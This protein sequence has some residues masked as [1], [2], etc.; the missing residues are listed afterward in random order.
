[1]KL[2]TLL[3]ASILTLSAQAQQK[4]DS[5]PPVKQLK[6]VNVTA[7]A[8][9]ITMQGGTMV[10]NVSKSATAAGATAWEVLQKAPG[11]I[12]DNTDNLQLNGKSVTVYIDGRPSRLSGEDLKTFLNSTPAGSIDKLELMSNPSTKYDAQ[13][14][15]IINI[16]MLKSKDF[17]TNG[18]LNLSAG[19]GRYPRT[20]EGFT[21]NHRSNNKVN[22][23]GSYDHLYARQFTHT[24]SDRLFPDAYTLEDSDYARDNR[25]SHNLKAGAD[26][27][28]SKNT[29]AG[30]LL[31]G[32]FSNRGRWAENNTALNAGG[33]STFF[34]LAEGKQ[35]IVNPS[36]N[37]YFKTGSEKKKNELSINADYFSY[38]KDWDDAF[39]A[40][41]LDAGKLPIGEAAYIRNNSI[42]DIRL[43]S[44]SADYTQ[45]FAF[46]KLEAGLKTTFTKTDNDMIWENKVGDDWQND[47]GKTNHFI[48]R[49]NVNA[50]YAGLSK[51]IKQ[52]TFNTVL[53]AE[54]TYASGNSL[55][56]AQKFRRDYVQLF[57]SA[58]VSYAKD[59][60]NQFS[61]SYRKSINRFGYEIVNPFITYKNAYTYMQGNPDIRPVLNHAVDLTWSHKYQ[62]FTTL[63][64]TRSKDNLSMVFRQDPE[65]RILVSSFD[66]QAS[67]NVAYA[68]IVF[69]KQVFKKLRTTWT[70][71]GLYMDV[72]TVLDGLEYK[73]KN[74]GAM[75]NTQNALTLPAGMTA[76]LGGAIQTPFTFGYASL[77]T[78]GYIDFGLRKNVLKG[79]GSLKLAVN[80]ILNTRQ[81]R[82]EVKYGTINNL[83]KM[84]TDTRVVNLT[85]NYRF[86]NSNVKQNK[87]RK[88]KIEAEAGRTNTQTM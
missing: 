87:T 25:H 18:T 49:E 57:P 37:V 78:V 9:V 10:M 74:F 79:K 43:Y 53:R 41:Y 67:F 19:F 70:L 22:F 85:F 83:S 69:T 31:K 17:G 33:D 3:S 4:K 56:I 5:V 64:F 84:N 86:G 11:V 6:E 65:T 40:R 26:V 21:L 71:T 28:F 54:H 34:Q 42:S 48:Y 13:G 14:A 30:I 51:T 16:K 24:T 75:L 68:N 73:K 36:L 59:A 76:E 47:A 81:N 80:D 12:A 77:K 63:G 82:F 20:S 23:Y 8:P 7:T 2:I 1:M 88:S 39:N 29:A 35:S 15:A 50:A 55:T 45:T 62:L 72:N 52:F 60:M 46:A 66:N 44:L 61:L 32:S 38:S 58:S 27:D